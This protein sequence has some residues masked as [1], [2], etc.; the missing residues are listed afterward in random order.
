MVSNLAILISGTGSNFQA[1]L[2]AIKKNKLKANISIVISNNDDAKGLLIATKN[3]IE[4]FVS[5]SETEIISKLKSVNPNLI[6]LAGYMKILSKD[7]IAEFT[8][9][10]I[11]IHPSLLPE[12]KGLNTHKRVLSDNALWHGATVHYVTPEL[13]SGPIIAQAK[14]RVKD[15]DTENSLKQRVLEQEHILYP[16][17][18]N[19]VLTTND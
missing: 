4:T 16:Y 5:K 15:N 14:I 1:I 12:Y 13:D 19:K 9:K 11:N 7:F 3:N 18:I 17:A 6:V 8:N 2:K 10:I